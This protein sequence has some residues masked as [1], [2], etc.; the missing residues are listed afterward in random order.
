MPEDR[1]PPDR[2]QIEADTF[3]FRVNRS[4]RQSYLN[5]C[6][7]GWLELLRTRLGW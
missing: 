7:S 1:D 4:A 6:L 5:V 2:V 3:C